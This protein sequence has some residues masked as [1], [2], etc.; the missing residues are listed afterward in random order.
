MIDFGV[1]ID[2]YPIIQLVC[3]SRLCQ[4]TVFLYKID[5]KYFFLF[6]LNLKVDYLNLIFGFFEKII[7]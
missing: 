2:N 6:R 5:K 3:P 7:S 1:K 4:S